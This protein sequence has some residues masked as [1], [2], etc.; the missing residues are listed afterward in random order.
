M[1]RVLDM[2]NYLYLVVLVLVGAGYFQILKFSLEL[3][4]E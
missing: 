2:L 3:N 1:Q 4:G